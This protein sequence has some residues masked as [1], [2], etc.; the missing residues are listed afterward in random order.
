MNIACIIRTLKI[1]KWYFTLLTKKHWIQKSAKLDSLNAGIYQLF[2]KRIIETK[3]TSM[4]VG[5][6]LYVGV[7]GKH[8]K[9]LA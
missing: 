1:N 4:C 8:F 9:K 5:V 6:F 2:S 3:E 7:I